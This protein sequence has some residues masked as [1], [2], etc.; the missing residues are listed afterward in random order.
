[1]EKIL[2]ET[3]GGWLEIIRK[4]TPVAADRRSRWSCARTTAT[5]A[6]RRDTVAP[7][8]ALAEVARSWDSPVKDW[9]QLISLEFKPF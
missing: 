1:M 2:I 9:N 3:I 6:S 7:T 8:K 4:K 5:P